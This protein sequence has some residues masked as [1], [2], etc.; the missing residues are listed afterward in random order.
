MYNLGEINKQTEINKT[1]K[2]PEQLKKHGL[3]MWLPPT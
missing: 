3:E 1:T 2:L